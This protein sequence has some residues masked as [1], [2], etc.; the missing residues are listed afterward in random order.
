MQNLY[1]ASRSIHD[2][3]GTKGLFILTCV[4]YKFT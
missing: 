3:S 2:K 4:E 1:C